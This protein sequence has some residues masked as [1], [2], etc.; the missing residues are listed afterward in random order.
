MSAAEDR[1]PTAAEAKI[2]STFDIPVEDWALDA[3]IRAQVEIAAAGWNADATKFLERAAVKIADRRRGGAEAR[4]MGGGP[5]DPIGD[6]RYEG[7]FLDPRA[8]PPRQGPLRTGR[9]AKAR[10]LEGAARIDEVLAAAAEASGLPL[11]DLVRPFPRGRLPAKERRR[12]AVLAGA[13]KAAHEAGATL[14]EIAARLDLP[15]Q[16]ISDLEKAAP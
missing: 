13:V 6:G 14:T 3:R 8:R 4:A 7:Y 16:R 5:T 2:L 9:S 11:D 15:V 10:K 12:R 1:N